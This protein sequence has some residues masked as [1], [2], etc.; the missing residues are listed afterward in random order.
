MTSWLAL[1]KKEFLLTRVIFFIG[2]GLILFVLGLTYFIELKNPHIT[3]M[4]L[5]AIGGGVAAHIFYLPIY[6]AVS[7]FRESNTLHLWLHSP[8]SM[9]SLLLAKLAAGVICM[10]CSLLLNGTIF[11]VLGNVFLSERYTSLAVFDNIILA[12]SG[13]VALIGSSLSLALHVLFFISVYFVLRGWMGKWAWFVILVLFILYSWVTD[14]IG[15]LSW[16]QALNNWGAVSFELKTPLLQQYSLDTMQFAFGFIFIQ[17][18]VMIILFVAS[19]KLI[20]HKVEV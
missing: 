4:M 2:L 15:S 13:G 12:G 5:G 19:A 11:L 1:L 6:T 14:L 10:F 3:G 8:H 18:V 7:L 20:D 17:L 16:V 9:Y